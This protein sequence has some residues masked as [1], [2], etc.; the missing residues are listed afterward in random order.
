MD[1]L[2]IFS[3]SANR[4]L[5]EAIAKYLKMPVG[6]AALTQFPDGELFL[7]INEDVRGRD[8]FIVQSTCSPQ[9][10]NLMELL[11]FIDAAHR[12]S[13][14]RVTA[15]M[16]YYGYA[17]QD[18]KDEGRVPIS[19]KL[20]ANLLQTAGA[21]RVLAVDLHAYQI[22]GFFDIPLDHLLAEPVIVQH[23]R[24]MGIEDLA[25]V[26]PDVGNVKIARVYA[27]ILGGELA[28]IDKERLSGR[29]VRAGALIGNVEGRNV[30]MVDDMITTGSTVAEA[31]VLL[32]ER[33]ARD[34]YV[35]A[36]HPVFCKG[37]VERLR[38]APIQAVTVTDSI[39]LSQE[40]Q[41]LE[42]L[43]VLSLAPLL[44]EAIKRI[45]LHQSVSELFLTHKEATA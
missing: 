14:E 16:P 1:Q 43:E 36:T 13:A 30:L 32:K 19:A 31:A 25:V 18:R 9:N 6:K 7:K 21:D 27:G 22:Q 45:H 38:Q 41:T 4:P 33:G 15:V 17:R 10:D 2:K 12:S 23:Y 35:A 11:L 39:P 8:I 26:S 37:S 28:I 20:V 42:N 3:G 5:A 34:I 44:G 40:A 29:D 24:D